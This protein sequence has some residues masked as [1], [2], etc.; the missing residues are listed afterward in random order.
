MRNLLIVLY[1]IILTLE[2]CCKE[3][4]NCKNE[5][6]NIKPFS[7]KLYIYWCNNGDGEHSYVFNNSSQIDSLKP[8]CFFTAPVA[9]TIPEKNMK[10]FII[11]KVS[12]HKRD[13]FY[14]SL[15]KDTCSKILTYK[16]DKIQR[17][18]TKWEFPGVQSV[19][20]SVENI[21]SDYQVEVKYKYVP[22]PE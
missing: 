13:T 20:C 11:G 4:H 9:F 1:I 8:T 10:Y 17:D 22:L 5:P 2:G 14:T 19:F 18:T 16:V 12:Y 21:P 3:K 15:E 6:L 7:E